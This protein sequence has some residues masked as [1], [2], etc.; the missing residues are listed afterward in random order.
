MSEK[1]FWASEQ[2]TVSLV[3]CLVFHVGI[4]STQSKESPGLPLAD[5]PQNFALDKW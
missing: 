4:Y 5:S 3:M 2:A 1:I